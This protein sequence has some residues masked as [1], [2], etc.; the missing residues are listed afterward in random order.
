MLP[1]GGI[2]SL[3]I[4]TGVFEFSRE[5]E[6]DADTGGLDKMARANYDTREA[7][8]I[9][10]RLRAEM[11]ATAAARG[12]RSRK[13]KDRGIFATHPPTAE[14]VAYLR[15]MAQRQP[16]HPGAT[17]LA[18][19][20][21][22]LAPYWP[23]FLDDQLKRND[24]GAGEYLLQNMAGPDPGGWTPGLLYARGE[25]YRRRAAPGDL[26]KAAGFYSDAI[27]QGGD[28]P[29]VWRGRGLT[30]LKLGQDG[31]GKTDL[32]EYLKR[33]PGASDHAMMAMMAGGNP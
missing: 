3:G 1:F 15:D 2:V 19:Y 20:R 18:A 4:L 21:Q 16:G 22:A 33:A 30:E 8:A 13:D 12:T 23:M 29:E 17:G 32:A 9:W 14:R 31:A 5:M 26:E 11:D 25:L 27:R 7:A 28:V 24:L 6:H 10:E